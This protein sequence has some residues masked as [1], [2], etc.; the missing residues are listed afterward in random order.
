MPRII[1]GRHGLGSKEQPSDG[2]SH[3]RQ[4]ATRRDAKNHFTVGIDDDVMHT[5]LP[6]DETQE[7]IHPA[8]TSALFYGLGSDGT[9]G[10]NKNSIKIIGDLTERY[11]TQGYF[12][13]DS[14]N[15]DP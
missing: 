9:V 5:S 2:S 13:Y 14:K 6:I 7:L 12:V 1:G 3:H 11:S 15:L 10:A 8:E 4:R